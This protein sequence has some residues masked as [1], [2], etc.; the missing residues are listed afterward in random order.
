VTNEAAVA[1]LDN[2]NYRKAVDL[3]QSS[4]AIREKVLDKDHPSM[5]DVLNNLAVL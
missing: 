5:A 1:C 3:L 2:G 4:I